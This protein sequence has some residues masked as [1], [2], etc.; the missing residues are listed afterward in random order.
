LISTFAH[1]SNSAMSV[2]GLIGSQCRDFDAA[3]EK[4]GSTVISVAPWSSARISVCTWL[5]WRFS[6]IWE[7]ISTMHREFAMSVRS[8]EPTPSP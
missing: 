3:T 2:P 1:A 8:G 4:R 6:P 7:P 5:L